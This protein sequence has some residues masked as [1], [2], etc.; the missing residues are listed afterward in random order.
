[1]YCGRCGKK[2]ADDV[3]FCPSCGARIEQIGAGE[4]AQ[5]AL[6]HA[7]ARTAPQ[8]TMPAQAPASQ[9]AVPSHSA[10]NGAARTQ[11]VGDGAERNDGNLTEQV[12]TSRRHSRGRIPM[13]LIII[14][15]TLALAGAAFAATYVYR[16]FIAPQQEPQEQPAAP[17]EPEPAEEDDS[18]E[19]AQQALYNDILA[20]YQES[21]EQGWTNA[22][23]SSIHDLSSLGAIVTT[24]ESM[25]V[26]VT[27]DELM[28]GT[29]CYAYTDLGDGGALGLE[30]DSI[31]LVIAVVQSDGSYQVLAVFSND[32]SEPTSLMDG[33]L[34]SRVYWNVLDDGTLLQT[35]WDG[36]SSGSL[37]QYAVVDGTLSSI[38]S[39][40]M[41]DSSYT[42]I[43]A[44]SGQSEPATQEDWD[45]LANAPRAELEWEELAGFSPVTV[46]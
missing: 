23:D 14:L 15:V 46:E 42:K 30:D 31:E 12:S 20:E 22:T 26:G 38:C 44:S 39:I 27:Y 1:M 37:H 2:I 19:L 6:T 41:L 29:V 28:S 24:Q 43:E 32:G 10:G 16:T 36:A 17:E 34:T 3:K 7:A 18:E 9:P 4:T 45:E 40:T 25:N 35:G 5:T 11:T 21:Q 13:V 8:A 33:D